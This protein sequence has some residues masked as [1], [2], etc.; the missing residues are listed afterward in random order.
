MNLVPLL[1]WENTSHG[2]GLEPYQKNGETYNKYRLSKGT[3]I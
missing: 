1:Q 3:N 2:C